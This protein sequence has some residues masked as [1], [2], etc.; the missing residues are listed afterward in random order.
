M[1]QVLPVLLAHLG[2][3]SRPQV[4]WRVLSS[5]SE[6]V[7]SEEFECLQAAERQKEEE[8]ADTKDR[9]KVP[10]AAASP[11]PRRRRRCVRAGL[12]CLLNPAGGGLS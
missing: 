3:S 5:L 12:P 2:A 7:R 9:A 8:G 6:L 10:A 4:I 11:Q 1:V